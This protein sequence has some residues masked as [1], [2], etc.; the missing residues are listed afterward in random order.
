MSDRVEPPD[1]ISFSPN[2]AESCEALVVK[3]VVRR[4]VR[5]SQYLCSLLN[6]PG[7]WAIWAVAVE[8]IISRQISGDVRIAN[9][10]LLAF[11]DVEKRR[12]FKALPLNDLVGAVSPGMT[13]MV[14]A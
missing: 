13:G 6:H 11:S 10:K 8:S 7:R 14:E 12:N 4:P 1:Q 2:T 9:G 3:P 5:F